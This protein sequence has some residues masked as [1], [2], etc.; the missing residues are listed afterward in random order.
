MRSL[1]NSDTR[2]PEPRT[3]LS[4]INPLVHTS[5]RRERTSEHTSSYETTS[6]TPR[7]FS[8]NHSAPAAIPLPQLVAILLTPQ[9]RL[10]LFLIHS[11]FEFFENTGLERCVRFS[12][13][14]I[15][16]LGGE[17]IEW[18]RNELGICPFERPGLGLGLAPGNLKERERDS[19][20][21]GGQRNLPP[22]RASVKD[23][24]GS[25]V[26]LGTFDTICSWPGTR[27]IAPNIKSGDNTE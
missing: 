19:A 20:E 5:H 15:R 2:T 25:Q 4:P 27:V 12:G 10:S 24:F 16:V 1:Y 13:H 18:K 3:S 8:P 23:G 26:K 7:G 21:E 17:E 9:D 11:L 6:F 22:T 14:N